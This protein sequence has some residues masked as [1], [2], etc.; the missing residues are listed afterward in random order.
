[1]KKTRNPK[2]AAPAA[3]DERTGLSK[4]LSRYSAY[5]WR[6]RVGL[7]SPSTNTT[8][9]PEFWRMAPEGISIHVARVHQAGRQGDPASYRRMA[10]GIAN[11]SMLLATAEVDVVAFGCTSCT[12][13]VP[14][15]EIHATMASQLACPGVL[16][17]EA[18]VEALRA[19]DVS[20]VAL[21]GPRTELVM[22]KEVEFLAANGFDAVSLGFLGLGAT[23]EERRY[24][25]RVPPE[26]LYRL[27]MDADRAEAQA[28]FVS[29]TQM[30]TLAMID[31]LEAELGKPVITSNQAT[32]WNCLREIG[33][34]APIAGCG[35]LF[36]PRVQTGG[37]STAALAGGF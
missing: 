12:Y 10:D 13:F 4:A 17:A 37:G 11:A 19:I 15:A 28:V 33:F 31:R 21:V 16:T 27:V 7:I 6:G 9:E 5:G 3:A 18:V 8:L 29:C 2:P 30:P 32:F 36:G 25:G 1:M 20:R 22:R 35:E 26:A 23:E 14:P 34:R 24:I